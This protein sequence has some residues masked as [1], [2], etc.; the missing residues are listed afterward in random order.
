MIR[1][2]S[3][4]AAKCA[5]FADCLRTAHADSDAPQDP[6]NIVASMAV[7]ILDATQGHAEVRGTTANLQDQNSQRLAKK[8]WRAEER[9]SD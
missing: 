4:N 1:P 7:L 3:A 8:F 2:F 9:L 5:L 6:P